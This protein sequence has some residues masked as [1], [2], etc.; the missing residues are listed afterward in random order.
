MCIRD[1]LGAALATRARAS[2]PELLQ[3]EITGPLGMKDTV[4]SVPPE[5]RS[6]FMQGYG[7]DAR[8]T[9]AWRCV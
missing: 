4:I 2:Y 9:P 7:F 6:R 8:P 1:R 5:L 3:R